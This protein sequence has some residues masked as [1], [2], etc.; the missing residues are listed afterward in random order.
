[1]PNMGL[2]FE[3]L[4]EIA[5]SEFL[6]IQKTQIG[7]N[8]EELLEIF[9]PGEHSFDNPAQLQIP[10][11]FG[12][13]EGVLQDSE[14]G[15]LSFTHVVQSNGLGQLLFSGFLST[16]LADFLHLTVAPISLVQQILGDYILAV[17]RDIEAVQV[18][19]SKHGDILIFENLTDIGDN[20]CPTARVHQEVES[21]FKHESC[22][23]EVLA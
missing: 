23:C 17:F 20:F 13:S 21:L 22:K 18:Q 1:M 7:Q 15:V 8:E 10:G 5:Y 11:N 9:F 4:G 6:K 14:L 16:G 2:K 19:N 12:I 3:N